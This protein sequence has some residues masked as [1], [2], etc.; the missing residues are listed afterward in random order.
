M[1]SIDH[2]GIAVKS[3]AAARV[4]YE[5]LGAQHFSRGGS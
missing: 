3:I 5:K 4:F 1:S 2:L